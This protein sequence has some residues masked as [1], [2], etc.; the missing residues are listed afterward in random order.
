MTLL[1]C[2]ELE[3]DYFSE[4]TATEDKKEGTTV[5]LEKRKPVKGS[6]LTSLSLMLALQR[7]HLEERLHH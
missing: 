6:I 4:L 2:L 3:T 5:S 7:C 1:H